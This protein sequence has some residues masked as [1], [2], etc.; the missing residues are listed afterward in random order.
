MEPCGTGL[1]QLKV[2]LCSDYVCRGC[3][4]KVRFWRKWR[5]HTNDSYFPFLL[6]VLLF[7]HLDTAA[8]T[9]F[10]ITVLNVCV[11][12]CWRFFT[13]M[14]WGFEFKWLSCWHETSVWSSSLGAVIFNLNQNSTVVCRKQVFP[15]EFS[16]PHFSFSHV[17]LCCFSSS[18]SQCRPFFT[19]H[20]SYVRW[21]SMICAMLMDMQANR[22]FSL[23]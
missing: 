10:R 11:S 15:T 23:S 22:C 18:F 20:N 9:C 4:C 8:V 16:S 1:R 5:W 17:K 3:L 7:W 19:K 21:G 13:A 14:P 12:K 6:Y 2:S